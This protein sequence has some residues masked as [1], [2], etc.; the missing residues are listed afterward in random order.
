MAE[1][2]RVRSEETWAEAREDYLTGFTAE[3]VCRRHDLGLSAFKTRARKEGWRRADGVDPAVEDDLEVFSD[4][5]SEDL[6]E[7][8][9]LR[10]VAA[11]SRGQ[12]AEAAR[13]KRLY[14]DLRLQAEEDQL[15]ALERRAAPAP[16]RAVSPP[17]RLHQLH[18]KISDASPEAPPSRQVRRR[19]E[20]EAAKRS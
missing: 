2:Y 14:R 8:A 12:S 5:G 6:I 4:V 19:L 20:R 18:S 11:I 9:R 3:E 10:L 16:R 1:A 17:A 15:L 7:M 13:W